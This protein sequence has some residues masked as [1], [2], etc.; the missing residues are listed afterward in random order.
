MFELPYYGYIACKIKIIIIDTFKK[1]YS[2][3][4]IYIYTYSII[5]FLENDGNLIRYHVKRN[6]NRKPYNKY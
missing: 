2:S 4:I 3:I 6:E 1:K 5:L